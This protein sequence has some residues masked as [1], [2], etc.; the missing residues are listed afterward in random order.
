MVLNFAQFNPESPDFDLVVFSSQEENITV[1]EPQGHI[2][3]FVDSLG[4]IGP[5]RHIRPIIPVGGG[6]KFL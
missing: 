3:G 5:I 4:N 2:A 1:R 6:E